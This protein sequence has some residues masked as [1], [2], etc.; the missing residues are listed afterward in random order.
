MTMGR[1]AGGITNRIQATDLTVGQLG[2]L[3]SV[4][5]H[6]G[7]NGFIADMVKEYNRGIR[8]TIASYAHQL[9]GVTINDSSKITALKRKVDYLHKNKHHGTKHQFANHI[10]EYARNV[11]SGRYHNTLLKATDLSLEISYGYGKMRADAIFLPKMVN[12]LKQ[13][14]QL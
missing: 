2:L 12:K 7:G 3:P 10:R 4:I 1:N 5:K 8:E 9:D 14:K 11:T 6:Y 13:L